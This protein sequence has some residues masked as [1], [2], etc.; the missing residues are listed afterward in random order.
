LTKASIHKVP[1]DLTSGDRIIFAQDMGG[2]GEIVTVKSVSC[3]DGGIA[4]IRTDEKPFPI[5]AMVTD[6]IGIAA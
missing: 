1:E 5:L 4:Y 2:T 6:P 3:A